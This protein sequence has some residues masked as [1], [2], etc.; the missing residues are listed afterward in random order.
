[1]LLHK[2][3]LNVP[4]ETETQATVAKRSLE[5]DPILKK[6][7]LDVN[8]SVRSSSLVCDF[9]GVNDRALRVAISSVID[10]LK[11]IVECMDEFEEAR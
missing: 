8:Y 2:V 10:N 3:T 5:P 6:N 9:S 4:F 1:M 11:T 7:E